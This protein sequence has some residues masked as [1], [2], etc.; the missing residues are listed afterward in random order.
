MFNGA[1]VVIYSKDADADRTFFLDVLSLPNVDAG[2]GWLIFCLPP[3][4][5]AFHPANEG[6]KHEL[7]LMCDD[8]ENIRKKLIELGV[9]TSDV[10]DEGW[11]LLM[12]FDLPSDTSL[13]VY[14]P[15]HAKPPEAAKGHGSDQ[16][17]RL[18]AR[19]MCR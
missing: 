7:Y 4:E 16:A 19:R 14:Q 6:G 8:I 9:D 17:L 10:S 18:V 3:S 15:R 12:H 13:G 1:H 2:G 11:G 5:T